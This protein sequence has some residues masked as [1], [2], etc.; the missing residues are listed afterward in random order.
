MFLVKEIKA[1]SLDFRLFRHILFL[2]TLGNAEIVVVGV[3][4]TNG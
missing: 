4:N 3:T 1:H 2:V